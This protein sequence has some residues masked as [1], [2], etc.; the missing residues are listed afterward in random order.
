MV[1]SLAR[2]KLF[3]EDIYIINVRFEAI[4]EPYKCQVGNIF[5]GFATNPIVGIQSRSP[6]PPALKLRISQFGLNSPN[7]KFLSHTLNTV[8]K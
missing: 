7:W 3:S 6:D 1:I 2:E 4:L 5:L 8:D